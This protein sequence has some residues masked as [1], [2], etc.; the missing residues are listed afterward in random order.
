MNHEKKMSDDQVKNV[1]LQEVSQNGH[2]HK[3]LLAGGLD[4]VQN[5]RT[6]LKVSIGQA[7][8]TIR[9]LLDLKE[10]SILQLNKKTNDPVD[11]LLDGKVIAHGSIVAVKD[12]F[13]V[14][15]TEILKP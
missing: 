7:E 15:I 1:E 12:D 9:E 14:R 10:D 6:S 8:L 11:I 5:V 3:P 4:L 2:S 13:G